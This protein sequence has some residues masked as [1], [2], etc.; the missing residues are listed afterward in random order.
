MKLSEADIARFKL[1]MSNVI[2]AEVPL[3]VR[4][5]LGGIG[6]AADDVKGRIDIQEHMVFLRRAKKLIDNATGAAAKAIAAVV[7]MAV[8]GFA[9]Y[10]RLRGSAP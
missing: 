8:A 1:E 9:A 5:E 10:F 7:V 2:R 3:I 6:L 4:N